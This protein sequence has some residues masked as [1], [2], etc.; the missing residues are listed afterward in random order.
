MGQGRGLWLGGGGCGSEAMAM[1]VAMAMAMAMAVSI[2]TPRLSYFAVFQSQRSWV[3]LNPRPAAASA[4]PARIGREIM[5]NP[6]CRRR[7]P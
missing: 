5:P 7:T 3:T 2:V 4:R 1:R 6:A